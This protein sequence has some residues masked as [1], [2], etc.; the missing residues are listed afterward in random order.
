MGLEYYFE[1]IDNLF[2]QR[3]RLITDQQLY[4]IISLVEKNKPSERYEG[5][6]K[7]SEPRYLLKE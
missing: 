2:P 5:E 3:H 6:L 4:E 7:N 1:I